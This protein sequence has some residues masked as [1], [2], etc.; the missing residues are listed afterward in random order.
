MILNCIERIV[1]ETL[2]RIDSRLAVDLIQQ[3]SQE[4][5]QTKVISD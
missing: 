1:K 4:L 5:T 3:A 2:D